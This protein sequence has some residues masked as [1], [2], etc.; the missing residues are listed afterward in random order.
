MEEP[1]AVAITQREINVNAVNAHPRIPIE[2]ASHT[3]PPDT[4]QA[5]IISENIPITNK[6]KTMEIATSSAIPAQTD[7]QKSS[8]FLSSN[9]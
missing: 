4:L 6:I 5:F 8:Y 1:V 9:H 3:K 7:F 2:S